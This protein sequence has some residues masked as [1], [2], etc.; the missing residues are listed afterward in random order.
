MSDRPISSS[1]WS[2]PISITI[3]LSLALMSLSFL[4]ASGLSKRL[5]DAKIAP[6]ATARNKDAI[7][8]IQGSQ[9]LFFFLLLLLGVNELSSNLLIPYLYHNY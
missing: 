6:A 3:V 9:L 8:S 4:A 5:E 2:T 7:N 1:R